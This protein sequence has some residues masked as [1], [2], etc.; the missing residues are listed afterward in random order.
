M[1][2]AFLITE[3]VEFS[4]LNRPEDPIDIALRRTSELTARLS[5]ASPV[6]VPDGDE[7]PEKLQFERIIGGLAKQLRS[8][9]DRKL[10]RYGVDLPVFPQL[11]VR[12][13]RYGY[14]QKTFGSS[15]LI[16]KKPRCAVRIVTFCPPLSLSA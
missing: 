13:G 10:G 15:E 14:N 11:K 3:I 7:C 1:A 5:L 16:A 6:L 9:L 4:M 8:A 12:L 2:V